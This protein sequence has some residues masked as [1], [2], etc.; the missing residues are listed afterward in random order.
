MGTG[1]EQRARRPAACWLSGRWCSSNTYRA[2]HSKPAP[3]RWCK[4]P[5]SSG[6]S[7]ALDK[8]RS[9]ALPCASWA[10]NIAGSLPRRAQDHA[11][12]HA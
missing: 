5:G 7:P 9:A 3:V 4:A 10:P 2:I 12:T 6:W 1:G 11:A 8:V